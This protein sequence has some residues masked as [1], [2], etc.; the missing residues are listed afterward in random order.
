MKV[1]IF[2]FTSL[3]S[4][5][6]ILYA[7]GLEDPD[8]ES[9]ADEEAALV[10]AQQADTSTLDPQ[11][12]GKMPDMNILINMFDTLV[13]IDNN[14]NLTP[15]L[16]LEWESIND[17]T[18]EFQLRED[19][20]FHNGEEFNAE[21]VKYSI[22]RLLDPETQSPI[23]EL[24]NV[25][26]VEIVDDYTVQ[27]HTDGP[28][29]ILP[30][31]LT[32]FGGVIVPKQYIEE[33]GEEH[34]A[35]NP[36]GTGPF[37]FVSWQKDSAV[38]M[39]AN[40]DYWDGEPDIKELIFRTI[41]DESNLASA[42]QTGEIDIATNLSPDLVTQIEGESEIEIMAEEGIRTFFISLDTTDPDSPLAKKEV[43]QALNY[44]VDVDLLIDSVLGGHANRVATILPEQNFGHDPSIQPYESDKDKAKELLAEA[45]YEDG[46][47]IELEA[48]NLDSDIV[49]V[50]AS[51]LSEVGVD[52]TINLMDAQTF[53]SNIQAEKAAPMYFQGNTG[54]TLD[55]MSNFQSYV[56][57][58]R[59]YNRWENEKADELV[60]II[61]QTIEPEE[62][63]EAFSEAQE[64]LKE[65][66]PFLYLYQIENL[67]GIREGVNWEPNSIGVL[68]M[69]NASK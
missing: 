52:V 10:V 62:R 57:S 4:M 30:N 34:F 24:N 44:A 15:S 13:G 66:A 38:N 36:I 33:N 5:F 18:W 6:L 59:R 39:E 45:G 1:K 9:S 27:I 12:Q 2:L 60:D 50:L 58:D 32:L 20:V 42:L 3:C 37:K 28:D 7:C 19:V 51:Q 67:Y 22:D 68:K 14:N 29:P 35:E 43:R 56:K 63:Q 41:P 53:I 16:A 65:E 64:L 55:G 69:Y 49:Q 17:T 31:K 40:D 26:S 54:W 23:V 46:I 25:D 21:T 61:E 48:S 11:K 47:S 8:N